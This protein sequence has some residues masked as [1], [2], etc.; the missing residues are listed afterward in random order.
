M[1]QKLQDSRGVKINV[2]TLAAGVASA[3][4]QRTPP[5]YAASTTLATQTIDEKLREL[6]IG[7]DV[8]FLSEY[9]FSGGEER[10]NALPALPTMWAVLEVPT[11]PLNRE[12]RMYTSRNHGISPIK[13]QTSS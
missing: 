6:A 8:T 4:V 2:K 7:S 3:A 10:N 12:N 13:L 11:F 9:R 1:L 5:L